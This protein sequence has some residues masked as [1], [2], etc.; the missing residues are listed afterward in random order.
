MIM[1]VTILTFTVLILALSTL[2]LAYTSYLTTQRIGLMQ[3]EHD[4]LRRGIQSALS[5]LREYMLYEA[6]LRSSGK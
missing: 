5:D 2:A 6:Q 1:V 3:I 4:R